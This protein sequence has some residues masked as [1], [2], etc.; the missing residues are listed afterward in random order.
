MEFLSPYKVRS[1]V[2]YFLGEGKIRLMDMPTQKLAMVDINRISKGKSA[3][4]IKSTNDK[5]LN[6]FGKD[7]V[8]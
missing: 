8:P 5:K 3:F 7:T 2:R 1:G 4:Y 6:I